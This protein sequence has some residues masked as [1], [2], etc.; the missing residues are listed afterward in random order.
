M[1]PEEIR[2]FQAT[3]AD[4]NGQRL[5]TD[6]VLGPKTEWALALR[7]CGPERERIVRTAQEYLGV[8]ETP[9]GS[10]R[11]PSIDLFLQPAGIGLGHP[12]CAAFVSYVLREC[13]VPLVK[14]HVSVHEMAAMNP[15]RGT[16]M[17]LPG[18]V[19]YILRKDGTG[20]TGFIIGGSPRE[21]MTLEGNVRNR[22]MVGRRDRSKIN[23]IIDTVPSSARMPLVSGTVPDLD[24][25]EDR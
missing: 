12:W 18:D 3:R 7:A 14:Y 11:S 19:F 1:T 25:A 15:A 20:H 22:V 10:N 2:A 8:V 5:S 23:G 4:W 21:V 16:S 17:A 24:G 9:L 13:R 6:G